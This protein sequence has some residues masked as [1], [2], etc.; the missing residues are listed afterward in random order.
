MRKRAWIHL[1]AGILMSMALL[2]AAS[3]SELSN[4]VEGYYSAFEE[5]VSD[6]KVER[7][8]DYIDRDSDFGKD[9]ESWVLRLNGMDVVA[10]FSDVSVGEAVEKGDQFRLD[11]SDRLTLTYPDERV[12][13]FDYRRTYTL[14]GGKFIGES[15]SYDRAFPELAEKPAKKTPLEKLESSVSS[16]PSGGAVAVPP[17]S[18][19]KDVVSFLPSQ[20]ERDLKLFVRWE[21]PLDMVVELAGK[22][23]PEEGL[24]AMMDQVPPLAEGALSVVMMKDGIPEI[25]GV[26]RPVEGLDPS[27]AI[28]V[29][30]SQIAEETGDDLSLKPFEG[31]LKS[32]LD[33]LAIVQLSDGAPDLYTA[34]WKGDG[35]TVLV[36][37][38]EQGLNSMLDSASG[39]ISS[40]N[41]KTS[42]ADSPLVQMRGWISNEMIRTEL[43]G[44]GVPLFSPDPLSFEMVFSRLENEVTGRWLTNAVDLF[45]DPAIELPMAQLGDD[46]P[47]LGGKILGFMA[48]R[49]SRLDQA[50]LR[51]ALEAEMPGENLDAVLAQMTEMTGLT[52]D[53]I[54]DLLGGRISMVFGGR[55][56]S[57]IGDVPGAFIQ[58]EPDKKEVLSKVIEALPRVLA[59][60]PPVG[61]KE[62][63][64]PGWDKV[65]AMNGMA[66]VTVAVD[67]DRLLFGALDYEK[68][69]EPASLPD[70]LKGLSKGDVMAVMAFS[71]ADIREV[72]KEIAEMNS[73]FLQ[74][75]EIKDGM[76]EF[77]NGTAHLD[78][79][80][81]RLNSL[82]EGSISVRTLR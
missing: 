60:T 26:I 1:V 16:L 9:V 40:L 10:E 45:V 33:P 42:L 69:D 20:D 56:R 54:L 73:I 27:E 48:A 82:K 65:Y 72:V 66:S 41:Y 22:A 61:L 70:N 25:Y 67:K 31:N 6:G 47:L 76:A 21:N 63:T 36:S 62:R 11:V 30:V 57:P 77:L 55:S 52:L 15:E 32:E 81:I 46:V 53:D 4:F 75:D 50:T 12:R 14:E 39:K 79:L 78:S 44:E 49:L 7:L 19:V 51:K 29:V 17:I 59:M 58:I 28:R 5:S 43:E 74:T 71:I 35:K 24:K 13:V 34:L 68:A 23:V 3:G 38:S 37:L 80:V 18:G 64:I 2:T 8:Y